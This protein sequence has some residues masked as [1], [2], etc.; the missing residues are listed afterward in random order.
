MKED[1]LLRAI[2]WLAEGNGDCSNEIE[3]GNNLN[4]V[5]QMV[6]CEVSMGS[7]SQQHPSMQ[8][9]CLGALPLLVPSMK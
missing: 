1:L 3:M 8:M 4:N 5:M 6:S 7:S 9:S 2:A